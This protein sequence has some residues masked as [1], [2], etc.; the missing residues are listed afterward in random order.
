M[1]FYLTN[2]DFTK[3]QL[4]LDKIVNIDTFEINFRIELGF[5]V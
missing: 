3:L 4:E 5:T 2:V 1:I